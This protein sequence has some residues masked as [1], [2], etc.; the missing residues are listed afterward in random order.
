[1][2]KVPAQLPMEIVSL[3][4][5][6]AYYDESLEPDLQVLSACAL[7]CRNWSP[8]AQTLLFRHVMLHSSTSFLA[9]RSAVDATTTRGRSLRNNVARL[10]VIIDH[11]HPDQLSHRAL[12]IAVLSCPN[13]YELDLA[14]YGCGVPTPCP[15]SPS[16]VRIFRA[17]P[18]FDT[19]TLNL[20]RAGPPIRSIKFTNWS[21]NDQLATQLLSDVWP[22][23][24]SV[25]LR[26][27]PPHLPADDGP[28][29]SFGCA[30]SDLRLDFQTMHPEFINWLLQNSYRSLRHLELDR[31]PSADI[32]TSLLNECGPSMESLSLPSCASRDQGVWVR[33]CKKLKEFRFESSNISPLFLSQLP[34]TVEHLAFSISRDTPLYLMVNFVK[35]RRHL[36]AITVQIWDDA[37]SHP[38]LPNL[39]IACACNGVDLLVVRGIRRFR[40]A[41]VSLAYSHTS[42]P[43]QIEL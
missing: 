33:G 26:G 10:K 5:E 37:A 32:L 12:A 17:A 38:Q 31:L 24:T 19:D 36:R 29:S 34:T 25:S 35:S 2:R 22:A 30:L 15:D 23:L 8:P 18:S 7:V 43:R 28:N 3:I 9:F 6:L 20:L 13:L 39:R 14:I 42:L 21:D 1:M 27:T 41:I 11:N 4:L 40:E 16:H